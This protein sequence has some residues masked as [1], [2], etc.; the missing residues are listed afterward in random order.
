MRLAVLGATGLTGGLL[1]TQALDDGHDVT[2]LV[3]DPSRMSASHPRLTILGGHPTARGDLELII[4][5]FLRWLLP[6]IS[7]RQRPPRWSARR[8]ASATE[9]S[10]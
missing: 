1:V 6:I 5:L 7:R 4:P 9:M 2:V 10:I 3:R 8:R